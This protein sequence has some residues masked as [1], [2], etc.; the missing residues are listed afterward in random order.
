MSLERQDPLIYLFIYLFIFFTFVE[1]NNSL[2]EVL[3]YDDDSGNEDVLDMEYSEAE[4]EDLKR[5]AE[6]RDRTEMSRRVFICT[7]LCM[8]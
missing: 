4:A 8:F 2:P 5:N 6:V 3:C 1:F 7:S